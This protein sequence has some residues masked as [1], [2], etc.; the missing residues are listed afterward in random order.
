ML[1]EFFFRKTSWGIFVSIDVEEIPFV[2][3]MQYDVKI[4]ET[5]F[6]KL[7][8][9]S[10]PYKNEVLEWISKAIINTIEKISIPNPICFHITKLDFNE[11]NFQ[12]EGF[13]YVMLE[14]LAKKYKFELPQLN[15]Y[16][17]RETNRYIFPSLPSNL[18]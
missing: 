15:A 4:T 8:W 9:D 1:Q 2:D 11:C 14:W 7:D 12:E 6:L 18:A 16:Y 10:N 5:I 3:T 17:D 13:Y